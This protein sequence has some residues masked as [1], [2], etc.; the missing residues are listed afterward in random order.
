VA[1]VPL[2]EVRD[3]VASGQV[4][5]GLTLTALLWVLAG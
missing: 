5:D 4:L 2:D 1:W 3:L